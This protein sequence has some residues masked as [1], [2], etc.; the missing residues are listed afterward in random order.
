MNKVILCEGETDAILLSYYLGKVAGWKYNRKGPENLNIQAD[1]SN[2]SVNWYKNNENFLLICAVGGKD[3][4]KNFF[5]KKIRFPLCQGAFGKIAIVTDRDDRE[6]QFIEATTKDILCSFS[7]E[8]KVRSNQWISC[9]YH[10]SFNIDRSVSTL[11]VV[12]PTEHQGA[13]ET[14]MLDAI[15]EDEYDRNIV[16]KTGDFAK[17]MRAEASKYISTDRLELKAH[18]SLT[19]A[20]QSPEKVFTAI[21]EQIKSVRWEDSETLNDCFSELAKI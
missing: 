13:L 16:V 12:I 1:T 3:N 21:D 4:F 15:S 9:P 20:V 2:Q 7:D 5:D 19:W 18:L 8:I 6:I 17:K 11:L 10:D 14:A